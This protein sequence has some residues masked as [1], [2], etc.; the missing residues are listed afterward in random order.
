[1]PLVL[2]RHNKDKHHLASEANRLRVADDREAVF[3]S[4]GAAFVSAI[5]IGWFTS[6]HPISASKSSREKAS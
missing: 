5:T 2:L 4:V 6:I 1:M 3:A